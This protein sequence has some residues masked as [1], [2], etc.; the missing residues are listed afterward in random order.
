MYAIRS[1]Y[2]EPGLAADILP[3]HH[4]T[5]TGVDPDRLPEGEIAVVNEQRNNFV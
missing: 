3:R 4:L 1:Y 2:A 5:M